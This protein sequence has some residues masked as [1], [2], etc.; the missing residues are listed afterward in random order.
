MEKS[1]TSFKVELNQLKNIYSSCVALKESSNCS[2]IKKLAEE[3]V[4]KI[5]SEFSNIEGIDQNNKGK[6]F[7]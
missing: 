4:E 3:L 7:F 6:M 1:N 2:I 5:E